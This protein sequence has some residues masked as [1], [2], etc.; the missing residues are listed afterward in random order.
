M[1]EGFLRTLQTEQQRRRERLTAWPERLVSCARCPRRHPRSH[2]ARGKPKTPQEHQYWSDKLERLLQ[3]QR[4]SAGS[5]NL[6]VITGRAARE[7]VRERVCFVQT[8]RRDE[9]CHVGNPTTAA[10]RHYILC[11][12]AVRRHRSC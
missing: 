4:P 11:L 2:R 7:G 5:R 6:Q 3:Q 8:D 9:N 12:E 10:W 1:T